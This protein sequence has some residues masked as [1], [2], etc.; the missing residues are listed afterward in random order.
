MLA[1]IAFVVALLSS[2]GPAWAGGGGSYLIGHQYRDFQVGV[3]PFTLATGPDGAIWYSDGFNTEIGRITLDGTV[4]PYPLESPAKS[5]IALRRG[6][7]GNLWFL[8]SDQGS[9]GR[10]TPSGMVTE[11][12]VP[13]SP[14]FG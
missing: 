6:P 11:F 3:S 4:K 10:I 1:R 9:I 5:A 13:G 12:P 8:D 14:F 2:A 7:D